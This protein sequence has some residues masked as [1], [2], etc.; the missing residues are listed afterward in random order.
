MSGTSKD[1][2]EFVCLL[3]Y[4]PQRVG[5]LIPM[6]SRVV[7]I[8]TVV[9]FLFLFC[10]VV[11]NVCL[12]RLVSGLLASGLGRDHRRGTRGA[13]GNEGL[14]DVRDHTAAGDRGLFR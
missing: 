7:L 11:L 13:L 8:N 12:A 2:A 9:L 1:V 14:V 10:F 5:S 6:V 4:A 3:V